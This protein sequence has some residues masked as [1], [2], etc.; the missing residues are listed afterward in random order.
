MTLEAPNRKVKTKW[1][2][3]LKAAESTGKPP[4]SDLPGE[5]KAEGYITKLAPFGSSNRT[6]WFKL[7]DKKL[8]LYKEEEGEEMASIELE[9][10]TTVGTEGCT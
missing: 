10:I 3:S 9:H 4:Q 8:A 1:I 6:R 5:L 7:T 2:K